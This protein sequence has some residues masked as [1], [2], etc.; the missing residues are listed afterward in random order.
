M[1]RFDRVY[2]RL[3]VWAQHAAVTAYGAYW[4]RL[5]FGGHYA[6][7]VAG[8]A[9]RDR[10]TRG[11]WD[12]WQRAQVK[13]LLGVALQHV[14][15]YREQWDAA[16]RAAATS[17][18]LQGIPL[19]E[20]E[21]LRADARAF[22]R[23]DVRP[24]MPFVFHTSGST[25]TPIASIWTADEYRNALALR[26][27][28]SAGWAG[29]SFSRPRATFS[30]RIVVPDAESEGPY[31]RFNLVERQV[32]LSA[33]HLRRETAPTYLEALKRH[34]VEWLTGYAVSYYLLARF[35]LEDNLAV[36]PLEAVVTTSEKVTPEMREVMERAY[37]CPVFEEYS[38]V[39]NAVFASD[40]EH[41]RL[42]VSPDSGI[43]ELLRA[44]GTPAAPGEPGEVVTTCLL[45]TYQ[46]MIRFRL[47]DL[48][49]WD[50]E[51][52]PCGRAMPVLKEVLGRV[53]DVIVGPDGREMVRFHGVFV[54]L[55]HVREGQVV[56]ETLTRV[57]VKVVPAAGYGTEDARE[58]TNRM[59]Q[60]LGPT[61]EIVVDPVDSIPRTKAGKFQ[62]VVSLL[63]SRQPA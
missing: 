6:A 42:H 33:F 27:V 45:R 34:R 41:H 12:D 28:R 50:P 18:E 3:P 23:D 2:A 13:E 63:A 31:H 8:Y 51:P 35:I 58:I 20:K 9:R 62:P 21:P 16:T 54:D 24:V 46:P 39:E 38:T 10:F 57:R 25:G 11:E 30:G 37:G 61:V 47:G 32:Y 40:C 22:L 60:R 55:P 59:H 56:Q 4:N 19:L 1:G 36:P 49:V 48:A 26:E 43:V 44:D 15:Y 29:V 7:H 53:E 5:R 52:C 14:P 17:G